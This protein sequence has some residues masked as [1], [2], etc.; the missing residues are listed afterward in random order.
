LNVYSFQ[1]INS[2]I[3]LVKTKN[4][5]VFN[6]CFSENIVFDKVGG[7]NIYWKEHGLPKGIK[8]NERFQIGF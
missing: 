5:P 4:I 8:D 2:S 7:D 3:F 1:N 6:N